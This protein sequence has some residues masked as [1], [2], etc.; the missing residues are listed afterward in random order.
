MSADIAR[1]FRRGSGR[2]AKD[3]VN[4]EFLGE[5]GKLEV[6]WSKIVAPLG[7]AVGFI[8]RE[9]GNFGLLKPGPEFLVREPFG[10]DVEQL[11]LVAF[12]LAIDGE[13]FLGAEGGVQSGC[14]NI[15]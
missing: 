12:E 8:D 5:A 15:F 11:E 1:D 13:G 10:S 14:G 2:E 6:I 3:T 7:D 4:L 9:E